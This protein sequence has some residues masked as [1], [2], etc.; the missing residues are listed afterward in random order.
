M[1]TPGPCTTRTV[2]G[3]DVLEST[4]FTNRLYGD[5]ETLADNSRG[6][7]DVLHRRPWH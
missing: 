7:D 2:G 4:G 3:D 1:A 5:A 6:G